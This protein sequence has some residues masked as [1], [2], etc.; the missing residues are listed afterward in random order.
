MK[1]SENVELKTHKKVLK[2]LMSCLKN[3]QNK[4]FLF[5]LFLKICFQFKKIENKNNFTKRDFKKKL[6]FFV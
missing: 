1:Y 2:D 3:V 5:T 6:H 4:N